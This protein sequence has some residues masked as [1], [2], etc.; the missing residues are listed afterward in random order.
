MVLFLPAGLSSAGTAGQQR[1]RLNGRIIVNSQGAIFSINPDGS[2]KKALTS[3]N[4][5]GS[6]ASPDAFWMRP[7]T[8]R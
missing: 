7:A 3:G 8:R 2:R 6:E 4:D 1:P 5:R